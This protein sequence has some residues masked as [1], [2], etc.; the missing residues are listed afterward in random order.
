[1]NK[2]LSIVVDKLSELRAAS[3]LS[4]EDTIRD[5]MLKY[6]M[7]FLGSKFNTVYSNEFRNA[8]KTMFNTDI[9]ES[10]LNELIPAA[11]KMLSMKFEK[12]IDVDDIGKPNPHISYRIILRE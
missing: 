7:L 1:M 3:F 2:N 11:C 6:N 9:P 5:T 8:L 12:M 4:N 10:E